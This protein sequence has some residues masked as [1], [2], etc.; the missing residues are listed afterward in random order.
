[1]HDII[2]KVDGFDIDIQGYYQ[3]PDCGQLILENLATR[4][5]FAATL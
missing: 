3:D 5:H 4:G 1:M 2:C